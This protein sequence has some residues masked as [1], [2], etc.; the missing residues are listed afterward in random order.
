LTRENSDIHVLREYLRPQ[1]LGELRIW[2]A[3][4]GPAL[5]CKGQGG[6]PIDRKTRD[7][8]LAAII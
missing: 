1:G 4:I 3:T 5:T 7:W 8:G 6:R 2:M